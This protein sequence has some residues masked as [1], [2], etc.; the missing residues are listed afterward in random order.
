MHVCVIVCMWSWHFYLLVWSMHKISHAHTQTLL[1]VVAAPVFL[2]G[3]HC[4]FN[5]SIHTSL[6]LSVS[7]SLSNISH[8][9]LILYRSLSLILLPLP[10]HLPNYLTLPFPLS[11]SLSL[12]LCL[13]LY[14]FISFSF[15]LPIYFGFGQSSCPVLLTADVNMIGRL[16]FL[17]DLTAGPIEIRLLRRYRFPC[18]LPTIKVAKF[19]D[20]FGASWYVGKFSQV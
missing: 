3:F 2:H 9:S 13:S 8:F 4:V 10:V 19:E 12:A 18:H 20:G 1:Q 16:L 6:S 14:R 15:I 11:L 7:V 17:S 5:S